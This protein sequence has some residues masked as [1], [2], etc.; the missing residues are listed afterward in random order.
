MTLYVWPPTSVT[1]AGV[2]TEATLLQVLAAVD[3]IETLATAI[4]A[5]VATE[6]TLA[7]VK[8]KT[9]N[10]DVAISTRATEATLATRGSEATLATRASEST[11]AAANAKL[12]AV[13]KGF[14]TLPYDELSANYAGATTDVWTSKLATVVQQV[15][16]IT[17][18]DATKAVISGV[19]VV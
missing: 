14:F 3:D 7:A 9:D 2:A 8:A 11:L 13:A 12:G 4:E 17:Y 6:T 5:K 18:T 1:I 15:L 19:K 16:T 10:L